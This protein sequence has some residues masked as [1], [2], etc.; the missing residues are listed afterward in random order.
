MTT[1]QDFCKLHGITYP[2]GSGNI[3]I[4]TFHKVIDLTAENVKKYD[5]D[6][7]YYYPLNEYGLI[8]FDATDEEL[9]K[10]TRKFTANLIEYHNR[11]KKAYAQV[12]FNN[13]SDLLQ[14]G[15]DVNSTYLYP[16]S[17]IANFLE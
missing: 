6:Y 11:T 17:F 5:N 8:N 9:L 1:I 4:K 15:L 12:I 13:Y 7:V 16:V 10:V 2:L 3:E 14:T